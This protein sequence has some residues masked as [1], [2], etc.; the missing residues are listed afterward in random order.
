MDMAKNYDS[1]YKF[2]FNPKNS[3]S[4]DNNISDST[5]KKELNSLYLFFFTKIIKLSD[6]YINENEQ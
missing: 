3:S 4:E 6:I 1:L 5:Y 2:D